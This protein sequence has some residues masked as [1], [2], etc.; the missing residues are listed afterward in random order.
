M[1]T[2]VTVSRNPWLAGKS[3]YRWIFPLHSPLKG[4][5][6]KKT[7]G[8]IELIEMSISRNTD[9][10]QPAEWE[11]AF[12][13]FMAEFLIRLPIRSSHQSKHCQHEDHARYGG[14]HEAGYPQIIHLYKWDFPAHTIQL[15]G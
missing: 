11:S 5:H 7:T 14:F 9:A 4:E 1:V 8:L 3:I 12:C 2:D 10:Y 15:W 6:V 13:A